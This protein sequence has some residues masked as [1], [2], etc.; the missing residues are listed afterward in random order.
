MN[1]LENLVIYWIN[2][3]KSKDRC[4]YM[5]TV[6]KDPVFENIPTHRVSAFDSEKH[7]YVD[8]LILT[9]VP[10]HMKP[11]AYG[12]LISHLDAIYRFSKSKYDYAI[13]FED[14]ISLEFKK[15]WNKSLKEIVNDCPTDWEIIQLGYGLNNNDPTA[16][17]KKEYTPM[18]IGNYSQ[19]L[20]YIISKEGAQ[21]LMNDIYMDGK[22]KIY[23]NICQEADNFLFNTL[24]TYTYRIPYF[25]NNTD[26]V[27]TIHNEQVLGSKI[28]K[29]VIREKL[30]KI[31]GKKSKTIKKNIKWRA[32]RCI[33]GKRKIGI[34]TENTNK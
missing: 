27:S 24:R 3:D 9:T 26:F 25:T 16:F 12:C 33:N 8:R 28:S 31:F 14:D 30:D 10:P 34:F 18:K 4:K 17:P 1:S 5:K 21:R 7:D 15:Y 20:S 32:T 6:L 11:S 13:I 22:Y 23:D 2:L 19:T 29:E